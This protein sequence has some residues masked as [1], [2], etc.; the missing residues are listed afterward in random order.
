MP[1]RGR[2]SHPRRLE[3]PLALGLAF[4][5]DWSEK[6]REARMPFKDREKKKAYKRL[7]GSSQTGKKS[8]IA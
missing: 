2:Q 1:G 4:S 5:V 3:F 7:W 8:G 6:A